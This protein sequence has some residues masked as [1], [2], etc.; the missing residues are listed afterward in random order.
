MGSHDVVVRRVKT[1]SAVLRVLA[2]A[3]RY[4]PTPFAKRNADGT[5]EMP[6][7]WKEPSQVNARLRAFAKAAWGDGWQQELREVLADLQR[8]GHRDGL[9][10]MEKRSRPTRGWYGSIRT[11][12]NMWPRTFT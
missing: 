4:W 6:N 5:E 12:R 9:I 11:L 8:A 10:R 7:E 3:Y 2:D 1:L